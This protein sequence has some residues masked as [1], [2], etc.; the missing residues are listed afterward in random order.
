MAGMILLA[1]S[2]ATRD[3]EGKCGSKILFLLENP[4]PYPRYSVQPRY[5]SL[6][7][8]TV[9]VKGVEELDNGRQLDLDQDPAILP[10]VHRLDIPDRL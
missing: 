10:V 6:S 8:R 7:H 9:R 5:R 3:G 2:L 1:S 4:R